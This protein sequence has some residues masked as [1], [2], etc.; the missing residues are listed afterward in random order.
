MNEQHERLAI[1][2]HERMH[3]RLEQALSNCGDITEILQDFVPAAKG[4][5]QD[6]EEQRD[7]L[8]EI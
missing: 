2:F 8:D 4:E 5:W 6:F 1:T 7:E 3:Y